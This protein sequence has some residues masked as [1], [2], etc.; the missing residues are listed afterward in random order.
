M[1]QNTK[2][3]ILRWVLLLPAVCLIWWLVVF[4]C[5]LIESLFYSQYLWDSYG[6][7]FLILNL[8]VIPGI[9]A[10]FTAWF[11]APKYKVIA[12]CGTVVFVALWCL[13]FIG[14]LGNTY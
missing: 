4:L 7:I 5:A 9:A 8:F 6:N 14:A 13:Y 3:D 1:K 12:G 10:F 11:L 2:S